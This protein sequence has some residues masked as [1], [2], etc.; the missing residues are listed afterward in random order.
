MS[1][2]TLS[3]LRQHR[4]LHRERGMAGMLWIFFAVLIVGILGVGFDGALGTYTGNSVRDILNSATMNASSQVVTSGRTVVIDKAKAKTKFTTDYSKMRKAY[5]N[6]TKTGNYKLITFKVSKT[7]GGTTG[8]TLT[9]SVQERS[10]TFFLS[11]FGKKYYT[12]TP[13]S[14]ARY[15]AIYELK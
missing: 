13:V 7:R 8:N 3:R 1:A 6:I 15:G 4:S 9:T 14:V 10:Q 11:V 5:P 2:Q 12:F